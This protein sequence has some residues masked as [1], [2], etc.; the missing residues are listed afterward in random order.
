MH[1]RRFYDFNQ[2]LFDSFFVH[3]TKYEIM[4][5]RIVAIVICLFVCQNMSL[6][7]NESAFKPPHHFGLHAG[8]ATG[9]G[10]SYRYWP[11]DWGVQVTGIPIFGPNNNFFS[12][13]ANGLYSIREN[14]LIDFFGYAGGHFLRIT[15][16]FVGE[17]EVL[18]LGAG[19]GIKIDLW[20]V[21]NLN[22]QTGYSGYN[23]G[24]T[25]TIGAFS[26]GLGIYYNM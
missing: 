18:T 2:D 5:K 24:G 3:S 22:L 1:I 8:A 14:R 23:I 10:F 9:L 4:I 11:S 12:F 15:A 21:I 17:E 19:F 20:D 25:S 6:A 13:G 26:G 7:Q 16:N